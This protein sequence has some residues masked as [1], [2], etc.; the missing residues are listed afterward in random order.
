MYPS[1]K[2]KILR[3]FLEVEVAVEATLIKEDS[4]KVAFGMSFLKKKSLAHEWA[5]TTLLKKTL[6]F[7]L[8]GV[9]QGKPFRVLPRK[10]HGS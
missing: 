9:L 6:E 2:E 1:L 5:Y 4:L 3:W 8:M 7:P 10:A